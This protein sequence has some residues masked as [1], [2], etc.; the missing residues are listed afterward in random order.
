MTR[1][2]YVFQVSRIMLLVLNWFIT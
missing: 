2:S 1:N